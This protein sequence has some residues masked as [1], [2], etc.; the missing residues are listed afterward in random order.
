[1]SEDK[2]HAS[3][4]ISDDY[5]KAFLS[6]EF[7]DSKAKLEPED[8]QKILNERNV[9]YGIKHNII[10]EICKQSK[11]VYD[12]LI[13]EGIPHENGK[14]AEIEYKIE[15]DHTTK[16]QVLEDGR[17]DFKNIG[18]V[19]MIKEGEVLA[20]KKPATKAKQGTTVTGK[21]IKG[22]DGKDSAFK[23]GKNC[24]ISPDGLSVI[25]ESDG[26]VLM[27]G[28]KL[29]IIKVLEIS[30]DVGV[31]TGNIEFHGQ[32]IINGNVTSGYSVEC[33]DDLLI[34]GVV[35]GAK[36]KSNGNIVVSRGIQGMDTADIYCGGSLTSNFINSATV[37]S[38][39]DI[40]AAA[41]MNSYVR[42][43]GKIV[44]KGKKGLIVGGEVSA[45]GDVEANVVGSELGV[46]TSIKIG[47]DIEIIEELKNLTGEVKEL[48]DMHNKLDKSLKLLKSK[49][50]KNPNDERSIIMYKKYTQGFLDMDTQ[51]TEKR[52]RLKM[53]N[54]L[55]N[56]IR[57]ASLKARK[58]FPG[59]RVKIGS[60]SYY[61]KKQLSQVAIARVDGEI[62]AKVL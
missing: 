56:N 57:G 26:S 4:K 44:V 37:Y 21:I 31:E 36:I 11:D 51:L 54:E 41:I 58:I 45:K 46:I 23:I 10:Q 35:E 39:G 24:K 27:Q 50:E 59:T 42:C 19:E 12:V 15:K 29:T 18:F 8:V 32:V 1:M 17:V 9:T 25:S 6:V 38:R 53:L 40:E 33:E 13:A 60:G 61:V 47:V 52:Q 5:Y 7:L 22:R 14:N 2:F 28:D 62:V 49:I 34:N 3:V 43:D 20:T 55:M 30:K 48:M 16:P